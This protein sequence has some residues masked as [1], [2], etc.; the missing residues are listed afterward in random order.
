MLR[1]QIAILLI[2]INVNYMMRG[3]MNNY[4]K[5]GLFSYICQ[6]VCL[7]LQIKTEQHVVFLVINILFLIT[8]LAF[9]FLGESS[10]SG[11]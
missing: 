2:M 3:K 8:T 11:I 5:F 4:Y 6:W 7:F 10:K 9:L 1:G